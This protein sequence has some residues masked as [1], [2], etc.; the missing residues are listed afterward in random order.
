MTQR[1]NTRW[2][3]FRSATSLAWVAVFVSCSGGCSSK[4]A[5]P[6][7][8]PP[9]AQAVTRTEASTNEK[10]ETP[11]AAT[12]APNQGLTGDER[13]RFYHLDMGGEIIPLDWLA[14]LESSRTLQPFLQDIERFGLLPDAANPDGLPVGLTAAESRDARLVGKMVGLNCA[15]C[16]TAEITFQG[17]SVRIDGGAGMF[18][19]AAFATDL[20]DSIAATVGDSKQLLA[21]IARLRQKSADGSGSSSGGSGAAA[22][23]QQLA[24]PVALASAGTAERAFVAHLESVIDRE[25]EQP[26]APPQGKLTLKQGVARAGQEL[27]QRV[28]DTLQGDLREILDRD[29]GKLFSKLQD[30][31]AAVRESI[32]HV[33]DKIRLLKARVELLK[34]MKSLQNLPTTEAGPGR[35]DDFATARNTLFDAQL[36]IPATAPCSIPPLWN[37]AAWSDWDGNTTSALGRSMATALAAGASFDPETFVSTVSPANL[38][39]FE[40][41]AAKILPPAW[42]VEAFGPVDQEKA[43]RG[44]ALFREHCAKCHP[45]D[46]NPPDLL[47]DLKEIGTDPNRVLNFARMLGERSFADALSDSILRYLDRAN[48]DHGTSPEKVQQI[49]TR[50]PNQWRT[51]DKYSWRPLAGV[52]ATAPYLHNGSVPT[53]DD[54]LLPAGQRPKKFPVGHREFDPIKVGLAAES[55]TSG[56]FLFGTSIPGNGN[57]GHEYGTDLPMDD[58]RA[59]VEFLKIIPAAGQ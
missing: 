13:E 3:H 34:K 29:A 48:R 17:K 16:H 15:A 8:P 44:Q 47:F 59:I 40:D 51:T 25:R 58:R 4:P 41:L 18:D 37:H 50:F 42:P 28:G 39:D 26:V 49:Q 10:Q 56:A 46:S 22:I 21:F 23:I 38:L 52:W 20:S 31:E 27:K 6:K 53:L 36:A 14:A 1:Q 43:S 9:N 5:P 19:A 57:A 35:A 33:V 32:E 11:A 24:D 7:T 55:G 54:L 12:L 2:L 30:R 45:T